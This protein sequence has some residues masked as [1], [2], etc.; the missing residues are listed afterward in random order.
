MTQAH[1]ARES[2]KL[3][4]DIGMQRNEE[5]GKSTHPAFLLGGLIYSISES[6]AVDV[7]VKGGLNKPE[8]DITFLAGI[9]FK[10]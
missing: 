3:V 2:F 10:F 1:R 5:K 6:I 9:A 7:G 8:T 4:A